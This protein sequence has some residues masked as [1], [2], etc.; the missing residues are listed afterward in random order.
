MNNVRFDYRWI[1]L[2]VVV[3]VL[4]NAQRL[5][6]PAVAALL[7]GGGGWLMYQGWRSWRGGV[8]S[9]VMPRVQYW[10][11]QRIEQPRAARPT[12]PPF[13]EIGPALIPL[14]VG[15]TMILAA[16]SLVLGRV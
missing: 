6:W 5:P 7:A 8:T 9:R 14:V 1:V 2:L 16:V 12:L 15:A 11:G 13:R 3:I 10:R 4:A